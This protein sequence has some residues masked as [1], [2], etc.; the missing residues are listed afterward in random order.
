MRQTTIF[1]YQA[2]ADGS[3]YQPIK[4]AALHRRKIHYI[5]S[6]SYGPAFFIAANC[7]AGRL[8]RGFTKILH[9]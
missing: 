6:R 1:S 3:Q 2:A 9:K 5:D 7:A 4:A 8:L